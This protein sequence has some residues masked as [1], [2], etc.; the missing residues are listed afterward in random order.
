MKPAAAYLYYKEQI[1]KNVNTQMPHHMRTSVETRVKFPDTSE[2]K[3]YDEEVIGRSAKSKFSSVIRYRVTG[4]MAGAIES[5]EGIKIIKADFG[6]E[7]TRKL[8]G[9][10]A[11]LNGYAHADAFSEEDYQK[12]L[13]LMKTYE[14]KAKKL[15][16][17]DSLKVTNVC[18][19]T[20]ESHSD[21]MEKFKN[22]K[23]K[24]R[25]FTKELSVQTIYYIPIVN[26]KKIDTTR[27]AGIAKQRHEIDTKLVIPMATSASNYDKNKMSGIAEKTNYKNKRGKTMKKSDI[28]RIIKEEVKNIL[29]EED[30]FAAL[31]T[32]LEKPSTVQFTKQQAI[33]YL[34]EFVKTS[35]RRERRALVDKYN[36]TQT[37]RLTN[38]KTG[39]KG[40]RVN[41][42]IVMDREI[43]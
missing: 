32:A 43:T 36:I 26:G 30:P 12:F 29:A 20:T 11:Y 40:Y 15:Q 19:V 4:D 38:R 24:I 6:N 22:D 31:D 39:E 37:K 3:V 5:E 7:V 10:H 13:G 18:L 2:V 34:K 9:L 28:I 35:T 23:L 42:I 21:S 27:I 33:E 25:E 16:S 17:K 8:S 41:G 14:I 1:E